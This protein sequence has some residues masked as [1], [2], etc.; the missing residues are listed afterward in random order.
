MNSTQEVSREQVTLATL[1][2]VALLS[3]KEAAKVIDAKPQ[4]MRAWRHRG[5]GPPYL[6]LT[7][8][9]KYRAD[10]LQKFLEQSRVVPTKSKR[11]KRTAA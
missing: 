8:K 3:E 6:R 5:V 10:D 7:G 4:T 2:A 11:R 9:I 1:C